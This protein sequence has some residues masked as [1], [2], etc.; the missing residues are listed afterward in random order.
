MGFD[1]GLAERLRDILQEQNEV[2]E[3]ESKMVSIAVKI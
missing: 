1:E 2:G 3:M